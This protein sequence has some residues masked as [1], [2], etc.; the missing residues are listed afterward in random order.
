GLRDCPP[1]LATGRYAQWRSC[2]LRYIDTRPNGD[3]LRKCILEGPYTPS[4]VI[5]LAVPATKN[6]PVVPERTTVK[7]IL[8]MS[9]ENKAHFESKKE[10]IHLLLTEIKDEI[11]STVDACKKAH[12]MWEA[13]ERQQQAAESLQ[14]AATAEFPKSA[15]A[16]TELLIKLYKPTNNNLKTSSNSKH[17]NVDSTPR[18]KNDNHTG[19]FG[20]QRTVN[21]A[22]A[23]E[24]V[25]SQVQY[26]TGY[27]VFSN[28]RHHSEQPESISNTCVVEKVDSNVIPDSPNMSDNDIQ[29]DQNA[30]KVMMSTEFERYKAL[31]NRTVAYDKLERKLNETLGL[32][33]QKEID[34]KEG[35]KVKAYE[36][37]VVKEKRDK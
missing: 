16:Y 13:I 37:S 35:L 26:D 18:Y 32:L 34:I 1:I 2:F 12:E 27:N 29:T 36:I 28:E 33:P 5:I 20:N 14:K 3:A 17:K 31:N 22:G 10:A 15:A 23:K 7:T 19:Q 30:V 24:T 8:N 6:A 4:T 11:Y 25:D 9:P 21:V